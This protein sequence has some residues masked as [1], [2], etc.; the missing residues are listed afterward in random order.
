MPE[1][2]YYQDGNR[3]SFAT[4]SA[5]VAG[6]VL[7]TPCGRAGVAVDAAAAGAMV[8]CQIDGIHK[9]A[10]TAS[11]LHFPGQRLYWDA[12]GSTVTAVP[13]ITAA[14]FFVGCCVEDVAAAGTVTK[15]DLNK[16]WEGS[17]DQRKSTFAVAPVLTAGDPRNAQ[18]GGGLRFI[19]DATN[20][21]QKIDALSHKAVSLD[22]DWIFFAEVVIDAAAGSATDISI[23]MAD[24][25]HASDF[26]SVASFCTIH[27]DGASQ[28]IL[29]QSDDG[30]TDVAPIDSN[31]NWTAAVP[32]ALV[33]DGRNPADIGVY[34]NGIRET[35][36][37]TTLAIAAASSGLK[38]C[39]HIE[40]TASTNT[41]DV[42]VAN[43]KV[44][45]ADL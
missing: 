19:L 3:I 17:I 31:L 9:L 20:E 37:G 35:A 11:E 2:S 30:S 28:D 40:K 14:D 4:V 24:G 29:V 26:Q 39:V 13:P 21:A 25:T 22:S 43:M 7:Q 12:S 33:I 36:T 42:T 32:F 1:A 10:K 34:V 5:V 6:E 16:D 27:V 18:V 23:G 45:T 38:A 41:A 44:L 8:T 15:V